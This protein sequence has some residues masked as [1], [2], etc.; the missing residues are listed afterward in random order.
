[1]E[2]KNKLPSL[3]NWLLYRFV[4]DG[5]HEEF[6]GDLEEIY[7][8]RLST[9][10][11]A[12]ATLLYW[13]DVLHLLVGFSSLHRFKN[14]TNPT[15]M[16]RHYFTIARRNLLRNKVYSLVNV[17]G[18]AVGIA[19]SLLILHYVRYE[20]SYDRFHAQAER[21]YRVQYDN[22]QNGQLT[23]QSAAAVPAVGPA[24]KD[25]FPEVIDYVRFFPISGIMT[26]V[27]AQGNPVSFREQKLQIA[28]PSA[29]SMFSF[30]LR[31]GDAETALDGINKV[32]LSE[33][34]ARRYFG[35]EDPMGKTLRWQD[36]DELIVT[37]VM[38]DVPANSHIQFDFLISYQTLNENTDNASETAWGWY[39]FNTYVVL[40]ERT[41]LAAFQ[42]KWNEWLVN[43]RQSEWNQ[44]DYRQEFLLQPLTDIHLYSNLLQ[45]SEPEQ[46]GN[47]NAVYFL[48]T[49]ALFIL[50]IAWI[51]YV[52]LSTARATE[53]ANE[54][55]VRKAVGA[56]RNQLIR[57]FLLE[58]VLIN[59][60][61]LLLAGL[62]VVA[63]APFVEELTGRLIATPP[64]AAAWFWQSLLLLLLVSV[65]LSGLYPALLLS[66]FKPVTVLR[67]KIHTTRRGST[68]RKGL[69]I[70]QFG[71][72]VAMIAGTLIVFR[73]IDFMLNQDLGV[74]VDQTLVLRGPG[75]TDSLYRDN[76]ETFK[77]ELL[78]SSEVEA[79]AVGSNVPG[80]EIF[81]TQGIRR[82]SG[83]PESSI[84]IYNVGIDYDYVPTFALALVAGRNFS[85]NYGT[86]AQG[87]LINEATAR[88]LEFD[89]PEEALNERVQVGGDTLTIL[90]VLGNYHQ[91]SLKNQPAPMV[92]RLGLNETDFYAIKLR[93]DHLSETIGTVQ[94]AWQ[95]SFPGN[96]M[97]YFL[98][99]AFFN[100]QYQG[101]ERF[102]RIFSI[103]A[104]LAIFI[105]CLGL[106]GL[107][108]FVTVQRTKE[109][110]VRKVLGASV[111]SLISLLSAD[112]LK[113]VLLAGVLAIPVA[114][115]AM[116]YWLQSYPFRIDMVW[117]LFLIPF[118]LVV[119]IALLTVSYQTLRAATR[120][121]VRS[122][123]YE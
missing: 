30:P 24:L 42:A 32:V 9:R 99:D 5:L 85:R 94:A 34:A 35:K 19:A 86:D 108:S 87:A 22:Y 121:P 41:D 62:L 72:S 75:I 76:L 77:T 56:Y 115:F 114:Y 33:S 106:F 44:N 16:Y 71:T 3:P 101:D 82:L 2:E 109:I 43:E 10:G 120:N 70:F 27:D 51:N 66:S 11:K 13:L 50:L 119:G 68:F 80:E 90:G 88:V 64:W 74:N 69:V 20:L 93:T 40:D 83:G 55:G 113:P 100:R 8:A 105:A 67:G 63:G 97:D 28:T 29:L 57:Q 73:Q 14:A 6:L 89:D 4:R 25:N 39:D 103:F 65:L 49:I 45:E 18:L 21:I 117:W 116:R 61:A 107:A 96:P 52:N 47:G 123:R 84:P 104:G 38:E 92:F 48:L 102:G 37:G 78:R 7:Q 26:Y 111:A 17:G 54:V 15:H 118:L 112:F 110:G 12:Y 60:L 122:L 58:A 31:A 79:I 81:W 59:L 1:M 46:Q 98:L 53:R 91:M 23:F 36:G 95:E